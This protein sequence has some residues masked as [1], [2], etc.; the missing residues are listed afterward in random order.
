MAGINAEIKMSWPVR[1]GHLDS[2]EEN[3]SG[4]VYYLY[5]LDAVSAPLSLNRLRFQILTRSESAQQCRARAARHTSSSRGSL[6]IQ[7]VCLM[8]TSMCVMNYLPTSLCF[9]EMHC[10]RGN[11][12]K[13]RYN[14][15]NF[16]FALKPFFLYT[17]H[18]GFL[19]GHR[20]KVEIVHVSGFNYSWLKS[21]QV[22]S[23]RISVI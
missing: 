20:V 2:E 5:F 21:A 8:E 17:F 3:Q 16:Q 19:F 7:D 15:V 12:K 6:L 14:C 1:G 4:E 9:C 22:D 23:C 11:G 18:H 10:T 13:N